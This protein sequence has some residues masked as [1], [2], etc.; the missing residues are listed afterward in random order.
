[1]DAL[2]IESVNAINAR[3]EKLLGIIEYQKIWEEDR[4]KGKESEIQQ[5]QKQIKELATEAEN[6]KLKLD[7]S[8]SIYS[9]DI[10]KIIAE[11]E[12]ELKNTVSNL[13]IDYNDKY[14][15]DS[16]EESMKKLNDIRAEIN[17]HFEAAFLE[18]QDILSRKDEEFQKEVQKISES[19]IQGV[20]LK[21]NQILEDTLDLKIETFDYVDTKTKDYNISFDYLDIELK[22]SSRMEIDDN[23]M[24]KRAATGA[25]TGAAAGRF[26]GPYG[27]VAVG[28]AGFVV[29]ALLTEEK[30]VPTYII[31]MK[32]VK[33][34]ALK[35][36]EK[37]MK[38]L[39][40]QID[41]EHSGNMN[42]IMQ[43]IEGKI[44]ILLNAVE[45][46]LNKL[47]NN[48]TKTEEE[49]DNEINYLTNVENELQHI[50]KSIN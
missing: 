27:M 17:N 37:Q 26:A 45:N 1:M 23:S 18:N 21:A 20:A 40:K 7:S 36:I 22:K 11:L 3:L 33:N 6:I 50:H 19:I 49:R 28:L 43:G 35:E 13:T 15:F 4:F 24:W 32:D 41:E 25:A 42:L 44:R 12:G 38:Y 30:E 48:L 16:Q 46:N 9:Q 8:R 14:E 39:Q 31:D 10:E 29:G 47:E 34:A 2:Y 5:A